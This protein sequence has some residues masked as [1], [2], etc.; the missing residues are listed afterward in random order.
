MLE[1]TG[2]KINNMKKT[3]SL[4]CAL[5][6]MHSAFCGDKDVI[7]SNL[8][9]VT[10]FSQGAQMKHTASY[11]IKNGITELHLEGIS[12]NLDVKSLQVKATGN[13]VIIDSKYT[14]YYPQ[15]EANTDQG[16]P[17]KVLKEMAA[18]SDSIELIGYDI[19]HRLPI[20]R[21]AEA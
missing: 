16:V 19:P 2:K 4:F 20:E 3:I 10:V 13:V 18:I 21:K 11:S 8:Y 12:A 7:K 9:E 17:A 1:C 6:M 15:P 14:L 5:W